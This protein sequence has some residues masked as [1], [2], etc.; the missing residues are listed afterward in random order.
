MEKINCTYQNFYSLRFYN[1][2]LWGNIMMCSYKSKKKKNI[3]LLSSMHPKA[4]IDIDKSDRH[5]EAILFYNGTKYGADTNMLIW[6]I[7]TVCVQKITR[8]KSVIFMKKL[9]CNIFSCKIF[10]P[11]CL[12]ILIIHI[13][14]KRNW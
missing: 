14:Y 2:I 13:I 7:L 3:Y 12:N 10:F 4:T 6:D 8:Q 9:N 11:K 1:Y 5:P